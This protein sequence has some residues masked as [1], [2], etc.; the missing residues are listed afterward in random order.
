MNLQLTA[1]RICAADAAG[2]IS[3]A[4]DTYLVSEVGSATDSEVLR[5]VLDQAEDSCGAAQLAGASITA[6][7][8]G[9]VR[10]VEVRYEPCATTFSG[11]S[12]SRVK[13]RGDLVWSF[14]ATGRWLRVRRGHALIQ[15]VPQS[16]F[17]PGLRIGWDGASGSDPGGVECLICRMRE[18]CVATYSVKDIDIA[19][20]R[21]VMRLTGRVNSRAF[22]G[23]EAGEVLFLGAAQGPAYRNGGGKWLTDVTYHF[24][25]S[26]NEYSPSLGTY[27]FAGRVDGW[28]HRWAVWSKEVSGGSSSSRLKGIYLTRIYRRADFGA[29]KLRG[30]SNE[31]EIRARILNAR[32]FR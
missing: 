8:G 12:L 7:P 15:R 18:K 3:G 13:R 4:R 6:D 32:N 27:S 24:A 17:N 25:I 20:K 22:H 1:R 31:A 29:L 19:F 2:V 9:G 26:P 28:D 23:W 5:T 14:D 11:D 21:N 16:A 10:E 30:T